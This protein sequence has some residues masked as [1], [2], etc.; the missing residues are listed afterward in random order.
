MNVVQDHR[1]ILQQISYYP[2]KNKLDYL[3]CN[4]PLEFK[5]QF[6]KGFTFQNY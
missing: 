5:N 3:R 4:E 2:Y 1:L 6:E